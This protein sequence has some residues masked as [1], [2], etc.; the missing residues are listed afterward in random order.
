MA[1]IMIENLFRKTLR[2]SDL[3]KT[4]LQHFQDHHIDWMHSCGGKGKCTTCKVIIKEGLSQLR[5]ATKAE[6]KY[7]KE[8]ALNTGERLACQVK[9]TGDIVV[10]V[11]AEYQLPHMRY[12]EET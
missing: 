8:G 5:P 9:I 7:R 4:L 1:S 10:A 3:S 12:S 6:E 2:V 11:P